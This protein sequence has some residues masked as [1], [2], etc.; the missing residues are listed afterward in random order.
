MRKKALLVFMSA[1]VILALGWLVN[2]RR[3]MA[4]RD[5]S[6]AVL[7]RSLSASP[8]LSPSVSWGRVVKK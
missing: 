1:M 8:G 6:P 3:A 5:H 4:E 2:I 7:G